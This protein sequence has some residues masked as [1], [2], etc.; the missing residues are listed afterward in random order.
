[1]YCICFASS[2]GHPMC[3]SSF[4]QVLRRTDRKFSI[5]ILAVSFVTPRFRQIGAVVNEGGIGDMSDMWKLGKDL[6][7]CRRVKKVE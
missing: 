5:L 7:T 4:L 1:M 6:L 3:F 2:L